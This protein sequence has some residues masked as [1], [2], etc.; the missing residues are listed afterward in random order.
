M[1]RNRHDR[2]TR[3]AAQD[4]LDFIADFIGVPVV[5]VGVGPAREQVVW[6]QER[7]QQRRT[8]Q[9]SAS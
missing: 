5:L 9:A 3:A 6:M 4:Y 8:I 2:V 7:E 1:G